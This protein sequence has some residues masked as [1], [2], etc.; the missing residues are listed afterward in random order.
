MK[1]N[2]MKV[3]LIGI[4]FTG[5]IVLMLIQLIVPGV[6]GT[7]VREANSKAFTYIHHYSNLTSL[8]CTLGSYL[9]Y[10]LLFICI[11]SNQ[12]KGKALLFVYIS[13]LVFIV[14]GFYAIYETNVQEVLLDDVSIN[15]ILIPLLYLLGYEKAIFNSV[16]RMIPYIVIL[17]VAL[18]LWSSLTFVFQYGFSAETRTSPSKEMFS[19]VI[20]AYWCY[21]LGMPESKKHHRTFKLVL[22]IC[23]LICAFL[24]QSRGWMVQCILLLYTML[25]YSAGKNAL[26]RKIVAAFSVVLVFL[27]IIILLPSVTEGLFN[28]MGEDT[29][30]GQYET[31]F[32]QVD[33]ASLLWG[34]GQHGSYTFLGNT[35]YRYFDNQFIYIMFHYGIV[36]VLCLFGVI[37]GLFRKINKDRL[38]LEEQA[39]IIGCRFMS[40]FYLAALGGLSVY[41]KFG[42]NLST[43]FVLIFIGRGV[44]LMSEAKE[45][46]RYSEPRTRTPV[47]KGAVYDGIAIK[48]G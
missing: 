19:I 31:F 18:I 20:S 38:T 33:A 42:W 22:G 40:F 30:S 16:K 9:L 12:K 29:R 43:L 6:T 11:W 27:L 13:T 21:A 45:R 17:M 36:P 46:K 10:L 37:G 41:F 14:W 47:I 32:S 39:Y 5:I 26:L 8:C 24:I 1:P 3:D 35:N 44:S 48:N 25:A 7:W 2:E 28:R 4:L 34:N 23:L 15:I